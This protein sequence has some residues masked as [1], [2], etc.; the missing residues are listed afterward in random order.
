MCVSLG[1]VFVGS[2]HLSVVRLDFVVYVSEIL[3]EIK[4]N[5][6][7][8]KICEK[9]NFYNQTFIKPTDIAD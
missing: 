5:K 1:F 7:L 2:V 4:N 9:K 3:F 8:L 6:C